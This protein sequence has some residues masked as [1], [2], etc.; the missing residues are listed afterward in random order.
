MTR[1]VRLTGGLLALA[2]LPGMALIPWKTRSNALEVAT[3][4]PRLLA[5][6][7]E[8][9]ATRTIDSAASDR[10]RD[11]VPPPQSLTGCASIVIRSRPPW[12]VLIFPPSVTLPP[13]RKRS[14]KPC[15]PA[16]LSS[17]AFGVARNSP[18]ATD[19]SRAR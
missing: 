8:D 18:L 2:A 4:R 15:G 3:G 11:R 12:A 13:P 17:A 1:S 16:S 14:A 5:R 7:L 10:A 19:E 9:Q 6:V